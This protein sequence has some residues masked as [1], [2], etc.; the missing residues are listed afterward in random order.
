MSMQDEKQQ[1]I[2]QA[3]NATDAELA[4]VTEDLIGV[5]VKKGVI[6]FTDLPDAVQRKLLDREALRTKLQGGAVSF[7]SDDETL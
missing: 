1:L 4:R 3:L 7:L 2:I 5:L 6:I